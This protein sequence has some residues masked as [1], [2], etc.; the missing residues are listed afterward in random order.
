MAGI[1]DTENDQSATVGVTVYSA[2]GV[3]WAQSADDSSFATTQLNDLHAS[4]TTY[5]AVGSTIS[6]AD[7]ALQTG[8]VWVSGDGNTWR[9]LGNFGGSFTQYGGSALAP[10]GMV[11]FTAN[12][13]DSPDG[14]SR[15]VDDLRLV[16]ARVATDSLTRPFRAARPASAQRPDSRSA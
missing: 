2:D 4:S 10:S 14:T 1:G 11:M 5:V 16:P 9:S 13:A 8:A 7:L 3:T 15:H 6:D 12:E